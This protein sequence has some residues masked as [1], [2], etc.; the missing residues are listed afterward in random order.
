M[1]QDAAVTLFSVGHGTL[2]TD[3]F[4]ALLHQA[5]IAAVVDVRR[6]PGS[7]RHPHFGADAMQ[8]WLSRTGIAYRWE[9][10]LGGR[11]SRRPDS[12]NVGLRNDSFR[13][14]AD[15]MAEPPFGEALTA[16]LED[17]RQRPT[18][19][20]CA[21][22]LWWRCHRRLIADAAVLV[23]GA[24]VRHLLHDGHLAPHRVTDSARR[25]GDVVV[26][27][28]PAQRELLDADGR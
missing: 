3:D 12:I 11:R 7:R 9:E 22:S 17:A 4:A 20:L 28:D 1:I 25:A 13:G 14:Y 2:T 24:D 16:V 6:F 8:Q 15:Y 26:Y 27:D 18:A 5:D 10:R 23:H 19:V 21:E